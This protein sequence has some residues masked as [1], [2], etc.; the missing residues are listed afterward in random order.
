MGALDAAMSKVGSASISLTYVT[1]TLVKLGQGAGNW[2][3]SRRRSVVAAGSNVASLLSGSTATATLQHTR[4]VPIPRTD[5]KVESDSKL[6][7]FE[8]RFRRAQGR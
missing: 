3:T 6:E 7:S 2:V 5:L 8:H 4:M 1:G